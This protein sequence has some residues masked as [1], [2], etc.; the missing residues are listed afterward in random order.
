M[1]IFSREVSR[2][3]TDESIMLNTDLLQVGTG[4]GTGDIVVSKNKMLALMY[5]T[6]L[7]GNQD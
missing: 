7:G 1:Y 3:F 5:L 4:L 2:L 6:D